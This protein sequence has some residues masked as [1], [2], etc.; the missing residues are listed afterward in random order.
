[1]S[2]TPNDSYITVWS[3]SSI[4]AGSPDDNVRLLKAG[5]QATACFRSE[6]LFTWMKEG[7]AYNPHTQRHFINL[8]AL[9]HAS[10]V[11]RGLLPP[12]AEED[13]AL[14]MRIEAILYPSRVI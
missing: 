10:I 14:F 2:P 3:T 13:L 8:L 1:M 4:N 12:E 9:K 5:T 7:D 6:S 11:S